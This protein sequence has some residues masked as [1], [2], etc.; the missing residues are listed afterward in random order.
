M[1]LLFKSKV[2]KNGVDGQSNDIF[3]LMFLK[4][5]RSMD[6]IVHLFNIFVSLCKLIQWNYKNI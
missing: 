5:G 6:I 4:S 2:V 1:I 3:A